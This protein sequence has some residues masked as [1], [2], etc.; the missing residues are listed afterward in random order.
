M[1]TSSDTVYDMFLSSIS[2]WRLDTLY[3][4]SGSVS[5]STYMEPWLLNSITDFDP[6][7]D[8]DL[9]YSSGSQIFTGDLTQEN[10]NMLARIMELYWFQK[11][12]QDTLQFENSLQDHDYKSFSQAQNLREKKD[13]LNMKKEE[14]SQLIND[15][16]FRKNDFAS[17]KLQVFD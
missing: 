5:L 9:T 4:V 11:R 1:A 3:Q 14:I 6:V 17:W 13:Y 12:T 7:C 2:D 16:A 15:Y 8:Q 10:I